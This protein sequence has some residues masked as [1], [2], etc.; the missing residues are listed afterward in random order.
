MPEF[1]LDWRSFLVPKDG[2]ALDECEDAIAGDESACRFAV[3]DGAAESY[4]SGDWAR[5]LVEAYTTT[6][7]VDNW[8]A[9]PQKAWRRETTGSALSWYAEEKATSGGH[10]TFL[11]I[12]IVDDNGDLTWEAIAAGDACLF[13]MSRGVLLSTFPLQHSDDFNT[14]PTLVNSL[15]SEPNWKSQRGLICPGDVLLMATDA[16]AKCLF[17]SAEA[18][19]FVGRD[20]LDMHDD[21]FSLW[22][23]VNRASGR[24]KNDDVALG[25]IFAL[26]PEA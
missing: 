13:V 4:A 21:D 15:N 6:G 3:A 1:T 22:V 8:L 5:R 24:L 26:E 14:T 10:A 19:A 9:A 18:G 7:P 11:G 12:S 2:H 25:V 16:L 20:L 17:E 23:A